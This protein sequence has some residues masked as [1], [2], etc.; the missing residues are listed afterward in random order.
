[1]DID[2]DLIFKLVIL[3]IDLVILGVS[4]GVYITVRDRYAK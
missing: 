3:G 2:M 4:I 1:M